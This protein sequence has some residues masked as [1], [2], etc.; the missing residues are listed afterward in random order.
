V[1]LVQAELKSAEGKAS[2]AEEEV[3]RVKEEGEEL[4]EVAER[5]RRERDEAKES[6]RESKDK[7]AA[8]VCLDPNTSTRETCTPGLEMSQR[9]R[10]E[11]SKLV[12]IP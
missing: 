6:E 4:R 1:F 5:M 11:I 9:S 2:V 3:V 10:L 12:P 8:A 7:E